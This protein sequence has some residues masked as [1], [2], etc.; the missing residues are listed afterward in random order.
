MTEST[1]FTNILY[2]WSYTSFRSDAPVCNVDVSAFT[3]DGMDE[4]TDW[5]GP[6]VATLSGQITAE[7]SCTGVSADLRLRSET[8]T[9]YVNRT[10][11]TLV[12]IDQYTYNFSTTLEGP[13]LYGNYSGRIAAYDSNNE[14]DKD[15]EVT[16]QMLWDPPCYLDI[17][18]FE[19][20]KSETTIND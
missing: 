6:M 7:T 11:P 16:N 20:I 19:L 13:N 14:A 1:G 17:V 12:Q 2:G 9:N 10:T 4:L 18:N 5:T 3:I 8:E 15:W